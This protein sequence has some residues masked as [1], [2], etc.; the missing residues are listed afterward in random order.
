[1]IL[2]A[3]DPRL[4]GESFSEPFGASVCVPPNLAFPYCDDL[5]AQHPELAGFLPVPCPVQPELQSPVFCVGL[6]KGPSVMWTP[7][8]EA[9]MDEHGELQGWESD[10]WLSRK[11]GGI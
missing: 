6:W 4:Q 1:M 9:P 3:P 10:V 11:V 5:P 7:V 2:S 8:P